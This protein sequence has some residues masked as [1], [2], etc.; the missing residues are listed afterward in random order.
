MTNK[1]KEDFLGLDD[2]ETKQQIDS[3]EQLNS[4]MA[5]LSP[6]KM[7]LPSL[8]FRIYTSGE[9]VEFVIKI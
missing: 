3:E 7:E 1:I 8:R 5:K 4:K 6:L 9:M 2:Q